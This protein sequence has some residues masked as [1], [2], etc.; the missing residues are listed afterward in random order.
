M[1][2]IDRRSLLGVLA[3]SIAGSAF[4]QDPPKPTTPPRPIDAPV[5]VAVPVPP[6][7][8]RGDAAERRSQEMPLQNTV[9]RFL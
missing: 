5:D 4:A 8:F 2:G 7:A 3:G 6:T 9:L 1:G